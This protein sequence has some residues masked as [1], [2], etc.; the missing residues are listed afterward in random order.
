MPDATPHYIHI[1]N[2]NLL[3]I[4]MCSSDESSWIEKNQGFISLRRI[5]RETQRVYRDVI[6]RGNGVDNDT[7][8]Q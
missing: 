8:C 7:A 2:P 5:V 1:F 4:V 6:Q 3:M